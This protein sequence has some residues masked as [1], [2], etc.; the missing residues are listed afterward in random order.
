M[1]VPPQP[2]VFSGGSAALSGWFWTLNVLTG[3][4][5]GLAAGAL[6]LL[7]RAVQHLAWGYNSEAFLAGVEAHGAVWRVAVLLLAG[8]VVA[9]Y[10]WMHRRNPP[11]H[12]GELEALWFRAGSVAVASTIARAVLSIVIVAMGASL[13]RE[14]APK[15][16][17]AA[18]ASAI[19]RRFPL[20]PAE[21]RL[22]TACAIGA[23]MGAVYNVPFGGALFA[24][25][26]MLGKIT[27]PLVPPALGASLIATAVAWLVLPIAP[28]YSVPAYG[29][30]ASMTVWAVFVGPL[31]GIA[32]ALYVRAIAWAD[33][34]KPEGWL[35]LAA[36]IAVLTALGALAI[37]YPELLGNGKDIIQQVFEGRGDLLL[38]LALIVLKPLV[39]AA[40]LGS[41]AP[42]GLFTPTLTF[43]ALLG[44][45]LGHLWSTWWPGTP[46]GSYAIVGA[47]AVWAAASQ[48][49]VSAFVLIAELIWHV[50][51]ITVPLM[52]AIA[53]A[54]VVARLIERRSIYSARVHA[55]RHTSEAQ[56]AVPPLQF[57]ELVSR[58]FDV[59]SA[60][61]SY[62][63][64][65]GALLTRSGGSRP[66][67]VVD[68]DGKLEGEM[69]AKLDSLQRRQTPLG[70]ITTAGDLAI[71]VRP[72]VASAGR[73]EALRRVAA[74]G[75]PLPVVD[76][77]GRPIAVISG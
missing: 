23:G 63:E 70:E 16:A 66:L 33:L 2:N 11:G 24:L 64:V 18:L 47:G 29:I 55:G 12:G 48:G 8:I 61:A 44:A 17:G 35:R 4:G 19:A 53:G 69:P 71:P 9:G 14:A 54:V 65:L 56:K 77:A 74:A 58:Q 50:S 57:A 51:A 59:I 13:G 1:A 7:L 30:S 40:C 5:A 6:M 22:L 72:L 32:A 76:A 36:P 10:R 37:P 20:P 31:A 34:R 42:G 60:A 21:Q 28:T 45:I 39:T 38:L 49:P 73:A 75:A 67:Y 27:L 26:V 41:G 62:P 68:E 52:L 46:M 15:Q 43:G 3:I 25:E